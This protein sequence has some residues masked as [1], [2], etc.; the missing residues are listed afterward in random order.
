[1]DI[2]RPV[3]KPRRINFKDGIYKIGGPKFPYPIKM[4]PGHIYSGSSYICDLDQARFTTDLDM[5]RLPILEPGEQI[6]FSITFSPESPGP[7][8]ANFCFDYIEVD[9][10]APT[11]PIPQRVGN[12]RNFELVGDGIA[13]D[14]PNLPR[15]ALFLMGAMV[16]GLG[17]YL[18]V[19]RFQK[20]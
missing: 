7:K 13:T 9:H 5:R 19:Y 4:K 3:P 1:M 11:A 12:L 2:I 14:L 16:L 18:A 6:D 15:W 20:V 8:D 10:I 17:A